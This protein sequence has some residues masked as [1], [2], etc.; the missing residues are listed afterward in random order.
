MWH[1]RILALCTGH[2]TL[3][4]ALEGYCFLPR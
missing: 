3:L 1:Q 4:A 2:P